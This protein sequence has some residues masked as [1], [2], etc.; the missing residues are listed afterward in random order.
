MEMETSRHKTLHRFVT[1]ID[2]H[3]LENDLRT[4]KSAMPFTRLTSEVHV[5]SPPPFQTEGRVRTALSVEEFG[6]GDSSLRRRDG[7]KREREVRQ[8]RRRAAELEADELAA[9]SRRTLVETQRRLAG[10]LGTRRYRL[11]R[12]LPGC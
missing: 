7:R 8:N 10:H 5:V 11:V 9:K 6:R 4:L 3:D 12:P 1:S 2:H